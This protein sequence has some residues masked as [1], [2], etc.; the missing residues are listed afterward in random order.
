M[1]PQTSNSKWPRPFR[2]SIHGLYAWNT[3]TEYM[4]KVH[5]SNTEN[6]HIECTRGIHTKDQQNTKYVVLVP[7]SVS[8]HDI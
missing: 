7:R 8:G 3:Y 1:A 6:T 4:H 2:P 5:G